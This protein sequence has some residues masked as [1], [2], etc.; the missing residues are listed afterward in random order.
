MTN[1]ILALI[2][3]LVL[4]LS[5]VFAVSC[6]GNQADTNTD[7]NTDASTDTESDSNIDTDFVE[8]E[9]YKVT[10]SSAI[11]FNVTVLDGA[12]N[13]IQ[14]A[15]VRFTALNGD[16]EMDMTDK[17]GKVVKSLSVGNT[18]IT[19]ENSA[20][21]DNYYL[22]AKELNEQGVIFYAYAELNSQRVNDGGTPEDVTDDRVAY[23]TRET[24]TY[25]ATGLK[26]GKMVFFLFIPNQDG[27]Y[28][29]S[30]NMEGEIG[31]Y[32]SPI[33]AYQEPIA[34]YAENGVISLEIK[35]RNLGETAEETTPYLIGIKLNSANLDEALFTITRTGDPVYTDSDMPYTGIENPKAPKTE[36]LDYKNWAVTLTDVDI[37]KEVTIVKGSDGYYHLETE[38]GPIVYIRITTE[39]QYLPAFYK[40]CETSLMGAYIRDE[41]GVLLRKEMYN[42]L[43]NQYSQYVDSATGILP[44]DDY[45]MTA[46]KNHGEGAG[47]WKQGS[48]NYLFGATA[49]NQ[50]SAWMF[51]CVTVTVDKNAGLSAESAIK[52]EKS[53]PD[54]IEKQL[55]TVDGATTLYFEI[56]SPVDSKL[57]VTG[58]DDSI[59]VIYNGVEY[60]KNSV[61]AIEISV[62]KATSLTFEIVYSGEE[63]REIS[64][65]I[66]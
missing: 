63:E 19:V 43:I 18:Y 59:K 51:A 54:E 53:L 49:V 7:T 8:P 62:E 52:V 46:V 60:T 23:V 45:M 5:L 55:V 3:A 44:L 33:N 29:F 14:N 16:S 6:G 35:N 36:R 30:M 22:V 1:K 17:N 32:G 24:G 38:D 34:P 13:P 4:G 15:V 42:T 26:D 40:I 21:K 9:G 20:T 12:E 47:W 66:S 27:I 25:Y 37:T 65:T 61:G 64:F 11:S 56:T 10:L 48:P 2:L 31:Y 57:K 39:S 28:S 50:S 41:N 58:C